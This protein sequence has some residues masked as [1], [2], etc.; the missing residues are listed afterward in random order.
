MTYTSSQSYHTLRHWQSNKPPESGTV[1]G[2]GIAFH[3]T[4]VY[5]LGASIYDTTVC[6]LGVSIYDTTVC[7]LGT[8]G[9]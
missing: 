3:D 8:K 6:G 1:C 2:L 9:D 7:G 5:G 4:T